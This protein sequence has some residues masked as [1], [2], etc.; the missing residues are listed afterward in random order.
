[1]KNYAF[2]LLLI[3]S[4]VAAGPVG[5]YLGYEVGRVKI[6]THAGR[7]SIHILFPTPSDTILTRFWTDTSTVL[8]ETTHQGNCAFLLHRVIAAE[9]TR[10]YTDTLV[11]YGDTLLR[12]KTSLA[13]TSFWVN[14]YLVPFQIGSWW[15][16]GLGGTY[17][18]DVNGDGQLDTLDIW[19]DT[20]R[21]IGIEDI[22]V[23]Y[24]TVRDCYKMLFVARQA[25]SLEEQGFEVRETS[26]V[27]TY[28]WYKDSLSWV[29]D[30]T[31][32]DAKVCMK[33][34][35]WVH[36]ANSVSKIIGQLTDLYLGIEELPTMQ[37]PTRLYAQPNPFRKSIR[38]ITPQGDL[39]SESIISIYDKSGR[40]VRTF[41]NR[42]PVIWNGQ[43][44]NGR[45][46][47]A[48]VYFIQGRRFCCPVTK[49]D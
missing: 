6:G 10:R 44:L 22:T 1:M 20:T 41:R 34:L 8:A 4:V 12:S 49:L 42:G 14:S 43:D 11:E 2:A 16:T 17:Y 40:C 13:D 28:E 5:R 27:R 33:I 38:I 23:P 3:C 18:V 32:L 45:A 35:I 46:L 19:G 36:V 47:P 37:A 7:D 29:K 25:L 26:Y 21:V 9:T 48:G 30:S 31:R 39:R 24:G 15:R